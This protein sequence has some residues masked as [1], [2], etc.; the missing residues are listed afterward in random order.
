[1]L[2]SILT[3]AVTRAL[4]SCITSVPRTTFDRR[5][6]RLNGSENATK[7]E[8][9]RRS[10]VCDRPQLTASVWTLLKSINARFLIP[11]RPHVQTLPEIMD[12]GRMSSTTVDGVV[13]HDANACKG[14]S[15]N[16]TLILDCWNTAQRFGSVSYR[17]AIFCAVS[18]RIH[19]FSPQPYRA[20]TRILDILVIITV[21]FIFLYW[22][23]KTD[24]ILSRFLQ[25]KITLCV[26]KYRTDTK[27]SVGLS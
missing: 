15:E 19:R 21:S 22:V 9:E 13:R 26:N 5:R 7:I 3:A 4:R 8:Y 10:M 25:W 24:N 20:I 1:L 12:S 14:V 16:A 17:I 18:Y 6:R 27:C 23:T 11:Y 2:S